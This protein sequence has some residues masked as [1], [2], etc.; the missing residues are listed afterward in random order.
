MFDC[1]YCLQAFTILGLGYTEVYQ[2]FQVVEVWFLGLW[3]FIL[4]MGWLIQGKL[5]LA[6]IGQ[7]G[8]YTLVLFLEM[9]L[10]R[11]SNFCPGKAEWSV[12]C[13]PA[14]LLYPLY[15]LTM[16]GLLSCWQQQLTTCRPNRQQPCL[17]PIPI[18]SLCMTWLM[19]RT[20]FPLP[21]RK[22]ECD[23]VRCRLAVG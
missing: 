16:P 22:N 13:T 23:L 3:W 5:T 7:F 6:L 9:R 10:P 14:L 12:G 15:H 11:S 21:Q 18:F 1:I 2:G 4:N 17:M 19:K 20:M 8:C